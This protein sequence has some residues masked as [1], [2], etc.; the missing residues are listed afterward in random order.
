[1]SSFSLNVTTFHYPTKIVF[2]P[3]AIERLPIEIDC[4]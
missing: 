2:G 4:I 3:S 1:M